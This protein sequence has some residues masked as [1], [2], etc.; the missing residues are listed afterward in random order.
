[1]SRS[2]YSDD[3]DDYPGQLEL[4][5]GNVARSMRGRQGQKMLREMR[6]ALLA[7]PVKELHAD[8]FA[9][10]TKERPKVCALGAWATQK[11]GTPDAGA[12]LVSEPDYDEETAADLA[13]HGWPKLVVLD[14]IYENDRHDYRIAHAHGPLPRHEGYRYNYPGEWTVSYYYDETPAERYA[15]VLAWVE[16]SIR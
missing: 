14:T 9:S 6:D 8:V 7:L 4:Y 11:A 12:A 3:L 1:M 15:R 10:G 5:R 16:G 2:S 13:K